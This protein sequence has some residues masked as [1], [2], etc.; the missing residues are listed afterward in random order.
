MLGERLAIVRDGNA[1]A[2]DR[3]AAVT[4]SGA[5]DV[6][7]HTARARGRE[8]PP[9]IGV[10]AVPAALD[11]IVL[12]DRLGRDLRIGFAARAGHRQMGDPG[13][14]LGVPRLPDASSMAV[15]LVDI[16]PST[17]KVLKL[18]SAARLRICWSAERGTSASVVRKASIVAMFG[19]IIPQPLAIPPMVKLE[20]RITTCFGRWSVV[21][22]PRAASSLPS[23]DS[24]PASFGA[25]SRI[26]C[27]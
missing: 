1:A 9:P 11:Q 18:S 15:S 4:D 5:G 12:D 26:G 19:A 14:A 13:H 27:I 8:Q 20:P 22:I 24:L 25:A 17:F 16:A 2:G 3:D 23:A 21:R 6:H 10:A 7:G